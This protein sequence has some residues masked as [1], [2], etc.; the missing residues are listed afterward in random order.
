MKELLP[1][2]I[3]AAASLLVGLLTF[4]GVII[5]NNKQNREVQHK[6]EIAQALNKVAI[7]ELTR[8]VREH[9]NFAKRMPIV[10]SEIVHIEQNI[11]ELKSYHRGGTK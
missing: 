5:T 4:V 9:N 3:S 10:E 6:F 11:E 2:I 8:E 7:D 1:A